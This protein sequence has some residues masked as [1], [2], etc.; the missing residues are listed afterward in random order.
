[1]AKKIPLELQLEKEKTNR[2][3]WQES[4]STVRQTAV[5]LV[6]S[7]VFQMIAALVAVELI[8]KIKIDDKPLVSDTLANTMTGVVVAKGAVSSVSDLIGLINPFD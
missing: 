3:L 5:V 8:Q 7:P 6:N 2:E 1:M 4:I